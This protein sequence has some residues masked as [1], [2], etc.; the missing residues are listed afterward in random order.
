MGEGV[1]LSPDRETG[2]REVGDEGVPGRRDLDGGKRRR[3]TFRY[4]PTEDVGSPE[5]TDKRGT[6]TGETFD[7]D[8]TSRD[9]KRQKLRRTNEKQ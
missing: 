8:P 7:I 2:V 1:G 3:R 4:I 9:K 6:S 5:P